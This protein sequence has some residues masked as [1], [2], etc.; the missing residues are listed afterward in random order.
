MRSALNF[1]IPAAAVFGLGGE[2]RVDLA[3]GHD[4]VGRRADAGAHQEMLDV[5]EAAWL[6]VEE[7]FARA[8]AVDAALYSHLVV[9][10]AK[11]LLAVREGDRD[12]REPEGLS[13]V[14][15]VE[16]DIHEFRAPERR[17]ALLAENP[18]DCVRNVRFT[19]AVRTHDGDKARIEGELRLIGEALKS[20]YVELL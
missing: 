18:A 7:I 2:N 15:A 6:L 17:R 9:V 10:G 1:V 3:L 13:R 19:A 12:F 4:G 5:P 20:D 8:I 16:Y 11:L 14:S